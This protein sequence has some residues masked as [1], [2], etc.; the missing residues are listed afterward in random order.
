MT[1]VDATVQMWVDGTKMAEYVLDAKYAGQ[2]VKIKLS[3]GGNNGV[4]QID[5]PFT[6]G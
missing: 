2:Q 6:L 3:M 1:L 5:I 4:E